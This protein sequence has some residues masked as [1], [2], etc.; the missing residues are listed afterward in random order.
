MHITLLWGCEPG[1]AVDI[2]TNMHIHIHIGVDWLLSA[3]RQFI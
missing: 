3:H 1:C 2:H